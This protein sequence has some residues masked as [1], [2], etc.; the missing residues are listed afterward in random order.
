M[1]V[2][3][4]DATTKSTTPHNIISAL[5]PS[6]LVEFHRIWQ[7]KNGDV[8]FDDFLPLSIKYKTNIENFHLLSSQLLQVYLI[9]LSTTPSNPN[10]LVTSGR[11]GMDFYTTVVFLSFSNP[12]AHSVSIVSSDTV[13]FAVLFDTIIINKTTPE[14]ERAYL[15]CNNEYYMYLSP[16]QSSSTTPSFVRPLPKQQINIYRSNNKKTP[17]HVIQCLVK[18]LF[19][20]N[21]IFFR[22]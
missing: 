13:L 20:F 15:A 4:K 2:D 8:S 12:I 10:V 9:R 7:E 5:V 16:F 17:M 3:K 6:C 1:S 18:F 11:M 21:G 19:D 22:E 14:F